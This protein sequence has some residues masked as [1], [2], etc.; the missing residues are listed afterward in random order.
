MQK[1]FATCPKGLENLL[2][3]ELGALGASTVKETV[4]GVSFSGDMDLAMR[5]CLYSRFASRVIMNLVTFNCEDDTDLYLG[6]KGV[7]YEQ[8]F[9]SSKTI[10][11]TFNGQNNSIRNTQYGALRVK[12]ALCDRFVESGHERPNVER[13]NPQVHVVAT[14]KKGELALG[15]DLSGSAQFWRE[16]HRVTGTAPLKENLAAALVVRSGFTGQEQNF[17]DPMCG[18]ATLLL[19]AAT[20]ATD[21][22]PGLMRSDYGFKHL[23]GFDEAA[24]ESILTEAKE[25]SAAG[26]AKALAAG[27]K[28]YG[29]DADQRAVERARHNIESAGFADLITVELGELHHL[30]N[31]CTND[32]PCVVVTNPPYGERMGNFNELIELYTTLGYKLR[33]QFPGGTA[34]IISSSPELLS[35]LRLAGPKTYRLYNGALDCQL[36][37]FKLTAGQV[38]SDDAA[39]DSEV[40]AALSLKRGDA[41]PELAPDFANR[42]RKNLKN[43]GKWAQREQI[44]A[45]RVYDADLPEYNAAIDRYNEYY[46]VQEYQAPSTIKP[47]VAQRRLLDMIAATVEVTG[48][49]GPEV[50][51]KSRERQKGDAQYQK[52]EDATG[53]LIEVYEGDLKFQ[54]NLYDYLDTGLFLDARPLRRIIAQLAA[55]KS[56]LNLFAY[57]CTASVAA[58]KGGATTTTSV[59]MSRTYLDWGQDNFKLNGFDV[60]S[61]ASTHHFKQAD[62][63]AYLSCDQGERF[64]LIYI[65]PPFFSKAKYDAVIQLKGRDGKKL[66]PVRYFAYDDIWQKDMAGYLNMLCSRLYMMKDLMAENGTIWVH[67]DWHVVH[68]VKV[69]MDEIFGEKNF[70]NEIIWQ[71]KSGGSGKRHY[72]RKHDTILVYSKTKDY[73]LAPPKEKSYNRGFKPYRFKGVKEYKDETGWYTMV[74]MKDIWNVDMVGRTS[75]ERTGYATQKPEALLK[76]IIDGATEEGDLCADFFCGS[77]TLAA[78]AQD[79]G[80]R[81]ICCDESPLAV[82]GVLKRLSQRSAHVKVFRA[83]KDKDG[84]VPQLQVESLPIAG[85]EKVLLRIRLEGYEIDKFPPYI[86]ERAANMMREVEKNDPLQLV[87]YWS[88]DFNYD[89]RIFRP[90]MIF[91]KKGSETPAVCEKITAAGKNM[92]ICVKTVDVLGNSSFSLIGR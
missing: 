50:I 27:I 11:V 2:F 9:D 90:E 68:Y 67:L 20:I 36:R 41:A 12:D 38:Q 39:V 49:R 52:R 1:F 44:S 80:R 88:V 59:D 26:K 61:G 46:I 78:A 63:L 69:L 71:Y 76:R 42:L 24:W 13:H 53:T 6:A 66:P 57:T 22:A 79:S 60:E 10:A 47:Q 45:Y 74:T 64:D 34:G 81:W 28:L 55:G 89:G 92:S 54:V 15:L 56:F 31:P 83:E 85:S 29:F 58:A 4:A 87:E 16:Y 40:K 82:S 91:S 51:V 14:L 19:E 43:L 35:C 17:V 62:C 7:A 23:K 75:A 32:F 48:A 5:V 33:T 65:D 18:A 8:Y 72:A 25:R 86:D 3:N 77:G 84:G 21:T 37:V 73:Y 30:H 70:V